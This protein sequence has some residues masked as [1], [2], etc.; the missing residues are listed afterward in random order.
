MV[1]STRVER[2]PIAGRFTIARGSKTEAELLVVEITQRGGAERGWAESV[3]YA[4]YGETIGSCLAQIEG[5]AKAAEV[6]GLDRASLQALLPPG[7]ARN[8]VDCALW[9]LEAKQSHQRVWRLAG[10]PPPTPV[11][12]AFTLSLATPAEMAAAARL[13]ADRPLLKLKIGG[14]DD[15]DRVRAVRD[16]APLARLIVDANEGLD[17]DTLRRL[18]PDL[19][20]LG[21]VLIEQP[22][23]AGEDEDLQGLDTPV[24]L[25]ADESLHTRAELSDCAQRYACLNI[26]LDK[27]GGL[28]EAVA[29]AADARAMGLKLMFGCMVASSLSMAP[30][31]LLAG[32]DDFVDL[33][34]PLLLA[35]DRA[36][37]LVYRGSEVGPPPVSLWG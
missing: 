31:L 5:V 15:L 6:D 20:R 25:C 14:A 17:L 8:A 10:L 18:L 37:G 34:G 33:D 11:T 19:H 32:Q 3:P 23:K 24:P 1:I 36:N 12:T 21:V 2:L 26:K 30:A 13:A 4:R 28:T 27:T 7:A 29:L 16:A 35:K 22:L 9:D